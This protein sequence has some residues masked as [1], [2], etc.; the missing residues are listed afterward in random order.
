MNI[1]NIMKTKYFQV[2][3]L[4]L[5]KFQ[6]INYET[7]QDIGLHSGRCV[8]KILA[9]EFKYVDTSQPGSKQPSRSYLSNGISHLVRWLLFALQKM[10]LCYE[11]EKKGNFRGS[12]TAL[13]K[14][15]PKMSPL[16]FLEMV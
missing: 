7:L 11:T 4:K 12:E 10:V 13:S 15:T 3:W 9:T 5:E 1:I 2:F 14:F 16:I 6:Q 8:E